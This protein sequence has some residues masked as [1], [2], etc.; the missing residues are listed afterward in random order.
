[1]PAMSLRSTSRRKPAD[2]QQAL[3]VEHDVDEILAGSARAS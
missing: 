2:G 3:V 1:M